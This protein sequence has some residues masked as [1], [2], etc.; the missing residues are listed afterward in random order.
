MLRLIIKF[1]FMI[2]LICVKIIVLAVPFV[3]TPLIILYASHLNAEPKR[4]EKNIP[5]FITIPMPVNS[6]KKG[7]VISETDLSLNEVSPNLA[8]GMIAQDMM[9]LVGQ[10][11]KRGLY[12]NKPIL[13]RDIGSITIIR[14]NDTVTMRFHNGTMQ[15]QT[16]GR[17]MQDGGAGDIIK[18][19][20]EQSKKIVTG[21]ITPN[22]EVDVS[23]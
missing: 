3:L 9:Q 19:M 17:A 15:L 13:L 12:K 5:D 14:R 4:V 20:N 8:N 2:T 16:V 7:M 23:L 1:S 11:A 18:V 10:E 6:I 22:G 21:H